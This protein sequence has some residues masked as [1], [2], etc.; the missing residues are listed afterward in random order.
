MGSQCQDVYVALGKDPLQSV[1]TLQWTLQN[2]PADSLI[3][4]HVQLPITTIPSPFGKIPVNQVCDSVVEAHKEDEKRKINDCMEL[5]LQICSEVKVKAR[6]LIVKKPNVCRGI[7]DTVSELGIRKLIMGTSSGGGAKS[8]KWK[9]QRGKAG[10]VLRHTINSC[11]ISIVCKGTLVVAREAS[12]L[13]NEDFGRSFSF[14]AKFEPEMPASI[15]TPN[16]RNFSFAGG[17]MTKIVGYCMS[18]WAKEVNKSRNHSSDVQLAGSQQF[19]SHKTEQE[20]T[21]TETLKLLLKEALDVAENARREVQTETLR[22]K[23]AEAAARKSARKFAAIKAALQDAILVSKMKEEYCQELTR[24]PKEREE[25]F[26]AMVKS[27]KS[28]ATKVAKFSDGGHQAVQVLHAAD[29]KLAVNVDGILTPTT[30][31]LFCLSSVLFY[32]QLFK[33]RH[34]NI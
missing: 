20:R 24:R 30:I 29:Q 14:Q 19:H 8:K 28:V 31:V 18:G 3:L 33:S 1:S 5:Y 10:Y 13:D 21:D 11:D 15:K 26:Q 9:M 22:R 34:G 7:A 23:N 25:E 2:K 16:L 17:F 32:Q 12:A 27:W 6:A 4:L